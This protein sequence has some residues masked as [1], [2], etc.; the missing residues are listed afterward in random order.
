MVDGEFYSL[1]FKICL[2]P[3]HISFHISDLLCLFNFSFKHIF[4]LTVVTCGGRSEDLQGEESHF[5][6]Y[7]PF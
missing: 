7:S 2:G 1:L 4:L 5:S 3:L 6:S